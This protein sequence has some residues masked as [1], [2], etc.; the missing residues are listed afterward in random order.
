MLSVVKAILASILALLRL[1]SNLVL[2]NLALRHQLTVLNRTAKVKRFHQGDRLFW[3]ALSRCWRGWRHALVIVQ[4]DTVV[5]WHRTAFR[6]FWTRR[7]G[8]RKPGRP[9]IPADTT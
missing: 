7:S 4:P 6:A 1:R 2:E 8:K 3:A 5:R 9:A